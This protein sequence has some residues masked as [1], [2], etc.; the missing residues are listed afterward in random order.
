MRHVVA[1]SNPTAL[2]YGW[3]CMASSTLYFWAFFRVV[4]FL[5]EHFLDGAVRIACLLRNSTYATAAK[6]WYR[7]L[8]ATAV[9]MASTSTLWQVHSLFEVELLI[10]LY[11]NLLI[12]T[13]IT[14]LN[15]GPGLRFF[16]DGILK[17]QQ[18]N[19]SSFPKTAWPIM[20][21][22]LKV[23]SLIVSEHHYTRK[24][25]HKTW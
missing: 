21:V 20:H 25:R 1:C 16:Y 22:Q 4:N 24:H 6:L 8:H 18:K 2:G 11:G 12:M 13:L 23:P 15:I 9:L 14:L 17:L 19:F 5:Y 3:S 10:S 7:L